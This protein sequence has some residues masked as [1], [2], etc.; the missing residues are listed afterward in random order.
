[1]KRCCFPDGHSLARILGSLSIQPEIST[2]PG[3]SVAF[4]RTALCGCPPQNGMAGVARGEAR[5]R[6]DAAMFK[7]SHWDA[8]RAHRGWFEASGLRLGPMLQDTDRQSS[9][10]PQKSIGPVGG[11]RLIVP[12]L[13]ISRPHFKGICI[14]IGYYST[15][16]A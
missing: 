4:E 14:T 11:Q 7:L 1:M 16:A 10:C 3:I 5:C 6:R 13:P 8:Q 15:R 9:S 2:M 12:D